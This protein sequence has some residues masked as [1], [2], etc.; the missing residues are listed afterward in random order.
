LGFRSLFH[1]FW[2]AFWFALLPLFVSW[3]AVDILARA[4]VVDEFEIWYVLLLFAL[5]VIGFYSARERLPFWQDRDPESPYNRRRRSRAALQLQGRVQ[6]ILKRKP[7]RVSDKGRQELEQALTE[8]EQALAGDNDGRIQAA[9]RKLEEKSARHLTFARKSATREYMESIGIAIIVAVIL[10]LFVVEAFKIPSESMVPTLMV[11]DHIFV[12]KYLYGVT[13]PFTNRRI[14]RFAAP[15]RGEVVVF[16]KPSHE[17]QYGSKPDYI[18]A[19]EDEMA[20]KD[21]IKRIVGVAGDRVEL[22]EDA[23]WVNGRQVPRCQLGRKVYRSYNRFSGQWE[24]AEGQL[25]VER[26]G[27][28]LYTVVEDDHGPVTT[29]GPITVPAGQVFLLGDNR[30]NSN[31]S[32]YWGPVPVDNIKGRAMII[33]WSNRR[34]HGFQW[35]RVGRLIM[36]DPTLD[37]EHERALGRCSM[38][39]GDD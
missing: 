16:A 3:I 30:D 36:T 10:R 26:H 9:A 22:R 38:L 34:P 12:S 15:A 35:D 23:L 2:H 5:L 21:F 37:E 24:N 20:G 13:L 32:R 8:L 19:F 29:F 18:D 25:W 6:R 31:D 39:R 17:E 28:F 14:V 7:H 33:W 4:E 27:A 1:K 11:G